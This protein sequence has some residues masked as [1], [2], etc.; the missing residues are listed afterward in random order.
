MQETHDSFD[1]D[2]IAVMSIDLPPTG[3]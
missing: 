3:A 2:R 1:L